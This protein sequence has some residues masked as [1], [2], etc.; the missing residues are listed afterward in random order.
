MW[1]R[2]GDTVRYVQPTMRAGWSAR[3]ADWLRI[4]LETHLQVGCGTMRLTLLV[5]SCLVLGPNLAAQG[6]DDPEAAD[7]SRIWEYQARR[8][9][10]ELNAQ[11]NGELTPVFSAMGDVGAVH[12]CFDRRR[13]PQ[14]YDAYQRFLVQVLADALHG[15]VGEAMLAGALIELTPPRVMLA[16][17]APEI[18]PQ[19][20][21]AGILDTDRSDVAKHVQRQPQRGDRGPPNFREY[22]YYLKGGKHQGFTSQPGAEVI[23]EHM[24][25]AD[26]Q[27]AFTA[28]LSADYGFNPHARSD[29]YLFCRNDAPAVRDLQL[30][31]MAVDEYLARLRYSFPVREN[32]AAE[33]AAVLLGL[34]DHERWWVRLYVACLITDEPRLRNQDLLDKLQTDRD[35][36]VQAA[37]RRLAEAAAHGR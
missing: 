33:V 16:M 27:V 34:A 32:Q 29:A 17:I 2:Y 25:R 8:V 28:M 35:E 18:G 22:V 1:L 23:V 6:Y 30:A 7:E 12:E 26:P 5:A 13:N 24:F 9:Y 37:V 14:K 10:G 20:K 4:L 31:Q 3:Y 36:H 15:D 11:L 19:D 21:L